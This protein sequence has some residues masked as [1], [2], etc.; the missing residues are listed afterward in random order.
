MNKKVLVLF[1]SALTLMGCTPS[2]NS[3]SSEDVPTSLP[4]ISSEPIENM[5]LYLPFNEEASNTTKEVVSG[6]DLKVNYIF[7]NAK[8]TSPKVV[9]RYPG[10][11]NNCMT[12]DGN[13]IYFEGDKIDFGQND[14]AVSLFVAPRAF[15]RN[16][17]NYTTLISNLSSVGGFEISLTNYGKWRVVMGTSRGNYQKI[18]TDKPLQLYKWNHIAV[19]YSK[20]ASEVKI[21]LNG[22]EI[23]KLSL[24]GG[25]VNNSEENI[26]VG[27]SKLPQELSVF[28]L[29][30][31]NGLLDEIRVFKRQLSQK[32]IKD[33]GTLAKGT[34]TDKNNGMWLNYDLLS[35][36]RY[37]PQY[38]M[39]SP[40]AWTNEHYGGFYYNG[41]YHIFSQHNPFRGYYQNG[42][43]WGHMT[44]DDLV[45]W[46]VQYP[47]LVTE[48]C[49]ID[50]SNAFSGAATFD[51]DGNPIIFY[52]GVNEEQYYLNSISYATPANLNDPNLVEWKKSY[53]KIIDQGSFAS[54]GEF[55]DPF[56]YDFFHSTR[57]GSFKFAGV[58]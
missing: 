33:L 15:E 16:D 53:T 14:F 29:N 2:L 11:S 22:V 40:S 56:V 25:T 27:R 54:Q 3:S 23:D 57:F 42:Q 47:A 34:I 30:H 17:G 38:H 46:D 5:A 58:A 13:S 37:L 48:D 31:F 39:R 10:V 28:T 21:Y 55:R 43:R 12:F 41:K 20:T 26:I 6:K 7:E 18:I 8:Y 35:D 24:S 32:E 19:V 49:V 51:K 52:T 36:D 9:Q 4:S 50:K 1:M 44:S 45:H